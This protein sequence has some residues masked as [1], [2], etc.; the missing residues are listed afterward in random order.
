M[1]AI[2]TMNKKKCYSKSLGFI[3]FVL[4]F[5]IVGVTRA[6]WAKHISSVDFIMAII[7]CLVWCYFL[8]YIPW[9]WRQSQ[10]HV[11]NE[12][13]YKIIC[14][15]STFC[16]GILVLS[17]CLFL[18]CAS[19]LFDDFVPSSVFLKPMRFN[20]SLHII[21]TT[22]SLFLCTTFYRSCYLF[23]KFSR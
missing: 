22:V 7:S 19:C 15:V 5:R 18:H 1:L 12:F 13:V 21:S 8:L 17:L 9:S 10:A 4:K 6:I 20:L 3:D 2:F 16:S 14:L 23:K 11:Q